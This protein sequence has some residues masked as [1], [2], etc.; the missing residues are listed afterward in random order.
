MYYSV[1]KVGYI[2]T[3]LKLSEELDE[4]QI[5]DEESLRLIREY[6]V[7]PVE[8]AYISRGEL[9]DYLVIYVTPDDGW[10]DDVICLVAKEEPDY[11]ARLKD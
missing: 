3:Q 10:S 6:S 4:I 9:A 1:A 11:K 8:S 7:F 5:E 2:K